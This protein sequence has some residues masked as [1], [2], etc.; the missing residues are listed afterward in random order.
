VK[1]QGPLNRKACIQE[2]YTRS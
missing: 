2:A 1:D